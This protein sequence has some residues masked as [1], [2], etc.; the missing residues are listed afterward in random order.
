MIISDI[1]APTI[2]TLAQPKIFYGNLFLGH[3]CSSPFIPNE[4]HVYR[5]YFI[6]NLSIKTNNTKNPSNINELPS[7]V[8]LLE[9]IEVIFKDIVD[10]CKNEV[11]KDMRSF[12][13]FLRA[14]K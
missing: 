8:Y 2:T 3:V 11:N 13:F 10:T 7:V 4:Q 9:K 6:L 12:P 1:A 5:R 14:Y